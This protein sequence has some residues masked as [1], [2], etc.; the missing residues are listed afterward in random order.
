[1]YLIITFYRWVSKSFKMSL[2]SLI[3][4]GRELP[5]RSKGVVMSI[6]GRAGNH[7]P[8]SKAA[9]VDYAG[10]ALLIIIIIIIIV[11]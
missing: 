1:M 3:L 2:S 5:V 4:I 11:A 9:G 8:S 6:F 10:E 7:L